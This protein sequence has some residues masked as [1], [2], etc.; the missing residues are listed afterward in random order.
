MMPTFKKTAQQ[1]ATWLLRYVLKT[2]PS[3]ELVN[4]LAEP[5][6]NLPVLPPVLRRSGW[7]GRIFLQVCEPFVRAVSVNWTRRLDLAV[8]VAE[9][10]PEGAPNFYALPNQTSRWTRIASAWWVVLEVPAVAAGI[11][12][13]MFRK[14]QKQS[15]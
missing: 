9:S 14:T 15:H 12:F 7:L 10:S 3:T 4:R 13:K 8:I 2:D 6:E 11:V 5:L 1:D